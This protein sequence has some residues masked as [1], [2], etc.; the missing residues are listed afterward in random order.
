MY[1]EIG[2]G[3][4]ATNTSTT[5]AS[6]GDT[7]IVYSNGSDTVYLTGDNDVESYVTGGAGGKAATSTKAG[8][9]GAGGSGEQGD[10]NQY[11]AHYLKNLS[12]S[13]TVS[14]SANT[15]TRS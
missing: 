1:V 10:E 12:T 3:G 7:D 13:L 5:G 11:L 2:Q 15:A 6:G 14:G 8:N 9:G 4:T